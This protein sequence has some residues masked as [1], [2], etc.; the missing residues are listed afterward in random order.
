MSMTC[1]VTAA[2]AIGNRDPEI[3]RLLA[4]WNA[5]ER[6]SAAE[7]VAE[8]ALREAVPVHSETHRFGVTDRF[9]RAVGAYVSTWTGGGVFFAHA[10]STRNG[11]HYG[12][13]QPVREFATVEQRD[14][15]L[16]RYVAGAKRRAQ[17]RRGR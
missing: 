17:N 16:K 5:A 2:R 10:V 14:A 15:W 1:P 13:S 11:A 9:R 8:E 7:T 6:D 4:E 12:A 3:A